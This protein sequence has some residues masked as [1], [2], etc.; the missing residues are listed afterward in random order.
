MEEIILSKNMFD[1][2]LKFILGFFETFYNFGYKPKYW[3]MIMYACEISTYSGTSQKQ[4]C[5]NIRVFI[6]T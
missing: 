2:P 4:S 6:M 1:C 5:H 3:H